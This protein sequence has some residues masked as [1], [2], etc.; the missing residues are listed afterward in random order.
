VFFILHA[1]LQGVFI[2][3]YGGGVWMWDQHEYTRD[4]LKDDAKK[5]RHEEIIKKRKEIYNELFV[6]DLTKLPTSPVPKP[7]TLGDKFE[8]LSPNGPNNNN[9]P[10]LGAFQVSK[11]QDHWDTEKA[12]SFSFFQGND[13]NEATAKLHDHEEERVYPV[14][15]FQQD[16]IQFQAK[17]QDIEDSTTL[18]NLRA[19]YI[20][21]MKDLGHTLSNM[22]GKTD[23][24]KI[25]RYN[26]LDSMDLVTA[27]KPVEEG[28]KKIKDFGAILQAPFNGI[29]VQDRDANGNL[30]VQ[31]ENNAPVRKHFQL[32]PESKET[33]DLIKKT[34]AAIESGVKD[35]VRQKRIAIEIAAKETFGAAL[36]AA[37]QEDPKKEDPYVNKQGRPIYTKNTE[38]SAFDSNVQG[39]ASPTPPIVP[40]YGAGIGYMGMLPGH[41]FW[42]IE[43]YGIWPAMNIEYELNA[44]NPFGHVEVKF[45]LSLRATAIVG[46]LLNPFVGLY[47]KAGGEFTY[48][49]F[50]YRVE[51]EQPPFDKK[52]GDFTNNSEESVKG[53]QEL[54][55]K[56]W[57]G[58]AGMGAMFINGRW[59][60]CVEYNAS[61]FAKTT[62]RKYEEPGGDDNGRARGYVYSG[63]HHRVLVRIIRTFN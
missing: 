18:P 47:T 9:E 38:T 52:G 23:E 24:Q 62:I 43:A 26:L 50:K 39:K 19:Y 46:K 58:F 17:L 40:L 42:G 54:D 28:G 25:A 13:F 55:A 12:N 3:V 14:T 51:N 22:D 56:L 15:R 60:F 63:L 16:Q 1:R 37:E 45:P 48:V 35:F 32:A 4:S 7:K 30:L 33:A 29:D 36:D 53:S 8:S 61:K 57:G 11:D 5:K 27:L 34:Q 31:G 41:A 44:K 6:S 49:K 2:S 20:S 21:V 10:T 59:A